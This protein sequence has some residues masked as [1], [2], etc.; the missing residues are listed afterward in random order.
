[1][2]RFVWFLF[3]IIGC[4]TPRD[5]LNSVSPEPAPRLE[6]MGIDSA[7]FVTHYLITLRDTSGQNVYVLSERS[8]KLLVLSPVGDF[9][10]LVDGRHYSVKLNAV[11]PKI[12]VISPYIRGPAITAW[13]DDTV[14]IWTSDPSLIGSSKFH[15]REL[16]VAENIVGKYIKNP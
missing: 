10:P 1:M 11:D 4:S 7:L 3:L 8:Q 12:T 16:F 2:S 15:R 13:V 6:L 14:L 9:Q 5:Q